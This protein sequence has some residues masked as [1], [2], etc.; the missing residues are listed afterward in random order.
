MGEG[1]AEIVEVSADKTPKDF[2]EFDTLSDREKALAVLATTEEPISRTLAFK[3]AG[4]KPEKLDPDE[5][6]ALERVFLGDDIERVLNPETT[7]EKYWVPQKEQERVAKELR[8]DR[9]SVIKKTNS[10]LFEGFF[11]E[12]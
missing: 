11:P 9:T 2:R 8:I 4:I 5:R 12:D 1:D 6:E 7:E 3:I 10:N